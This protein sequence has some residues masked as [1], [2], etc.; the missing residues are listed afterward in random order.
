[1]HCASNRRHDPS[2]ANR[3]T[4]GDRRKSVN[5]ADDMA[6]DTGNRR[7]IF[8]P[9]PV[10]LSIVSFPSRCSVSRLSRESPCPFPLCS[11]FP[12][13][14]KGCA[15]PPGS[16]SIVCL[17]GPCRNRTGTPFRATD[18][19]SVASTN[20]A[21]GP[22]TRSRLKLGDRPVSRKGA[23]ATQGLLLVRQSLASTRRRPA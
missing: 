7:H 16:A 23:V 21:K 18:F 13:R 12:S 15:L 4:E 6:R 8:A 5:L 1:M 2:L 11:G 17:G 10:T 19:K 22:F 14:Q 20:S 3:R 9:A